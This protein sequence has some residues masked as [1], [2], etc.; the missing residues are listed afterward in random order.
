MRLRSR[1]ISGSYGDGDIDDIILTPEQ[2]KLQEEILEAREKQW[3]EQQRERELEEAETIGEKVTRVMD[4]VNSHPLL[5]EIIGLRKKENRNR[6]LEMVLP[7]LITSIT[8]MATKAGERTSVQD[9]VGTAY[10]MVDLLIAADKQREEKEAAN[11]AANT[12]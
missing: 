7:P 9:I 10:E 5:G 11:A 4:M 2:Q 3:R 8:G 12:P 1:P 6:Y